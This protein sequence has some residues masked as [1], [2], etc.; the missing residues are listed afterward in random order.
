M[1][2]QNSFVRLDLLLKQSIILPMKLTYLFIICLSLLIPFSS[3]A[4]TQKGNDINGILENEGL[5][6]S[7]SMANTRT[8]A[9][10]NPL[11]KSSSTTFSTGLTRVYTLSG[12]SWVQKGNTIYGDDY[13]FFSGYCVKMPD[14]NT[15]AIGS[16]WAHGNSGTNFMSGYVRIYNWN[17]TNWI[18]KGA[19]IDGDNPLDY[20]GGA[21]SMPDTNTIAISSIGD[22]TYGYQTGKVKIFKWDGI[23][24]AQKGGDIIGD[25]AED[26]FGYSVSMPDSNTVAIGAI[27]HDANGTDAGLVKIFTWNG[28]D[29]IQKGNNFYGDTTGDSLGISISMSDPNTILMGYPNNDGNLNNAGVVRTYMWNG[30]SWVQKGN[31]IYGT[32]ASSKFGSSVSMSNSNTIAIGAPFNDESSENAG[33]IK[34]FAWNGIDWVQKGIEI[35]GDAAGDLLGYSIDMSD[36]NT[37]A[38]S[39]LGNDESA[40]ESGQ[41]KVFEFCTSN[42]TT[43]TITACDSYTWIDGNTYFSSNNTAS[44][45]YTNSLGCDSIIYL[46]LTINN[47]DTTVSNNWLTLTANENAA[48]YQWLNCDNNYSLINGAQNQ[49]YSPAN[50]GNFAVEI[51]KYGC[52][53]TSD[54]YTVYG[55]GLSENSEDNQIAIYPNPTNGQFTVLFGIDMNE[56]VLTIF[57]L[58]GQEVYKKQVSSSNQIQ[59]DFEGAKGV[60]LCQI[61]TANGLN[62]TF[63]LIKY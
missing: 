29:W 17:G 45:T 9:V 16:P 32:S 42:T 23:S 51:S 27:G 14:S 22:S 6:F 61:I 10:S 3:L 40:I 63:K 1:Y 48:T 19:D 59:I 62:Q 33:Q 2:L 36:S 4:Q 37:F 58:D 44:Y 43:Q 52:T 30:S 53:D 56:I 21:F 8:I 25:A 26:G 50:G 47:I 11:G 49:S 24:W 39:A 18:Q 34:V 54:C 13:Q 46:N 12:S 15:L 31:D 20:C 28:S 38:V 35:N 5:G 55:T 60:Y 7:I 41:I 57:T